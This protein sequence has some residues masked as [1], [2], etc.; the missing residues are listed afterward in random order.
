MLTYSA[1]SV[2]LKKGDNE[3]FAGFTGQSLTTLCKAGTGGRP[4]AVP[5]SS[6]LSLPIVLFIVSLVLSIS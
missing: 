3:V 1:K 2:L 5:A 6:V 4:A